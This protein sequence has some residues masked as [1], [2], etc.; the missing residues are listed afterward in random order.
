[1]SLKRK[2]FFDFDN[3]LVD[4]VFAGMEYM[5]NT[6]GV[7]RK[8]SKDIEEY[9]F[10]PLFEPPK[11]IVQIFESQVFYDNL[12]LYEGMYSLLTWLK[13]NNFEIIIPTYCVSDKGKKYKEYWFNEN[14]SITELIDNIIYLDKE[15]KSYLDMSDAILIDDLSKYH[16]MCNAG[17]HLSLKMY[18]KANW[19]PEQLD[20]VTVCSNVDQ[21]KQIISR[22]YDIKDEL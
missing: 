1:M 22:V 11:P 17:L 15:D 14:P 5:V 2:I 16:E 7:P 12:Y 18:P 20:Y 21:L 6:Y 8:D 4:S 10:Q 3:T 13:K 9:N 19:Y